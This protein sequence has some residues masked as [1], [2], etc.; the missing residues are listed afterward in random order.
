MINPVGH[1]PL[2]GVESN[3]SSMRQ[4]KLFFPFFSGENTQK[5]HL[6]HNDTIFK[7]SP[8]CC[9]L[10]HHFLFVLEKSPL[11]SDHSN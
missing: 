1:G 8:F 9:L 11:I 6:R 4:K 10:L 3:I 7:T 5:F 2:T